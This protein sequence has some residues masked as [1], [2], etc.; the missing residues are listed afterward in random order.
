MTLRNPTTRAE[1]LE[2]IAATFDRQAR[3]NAKWAEE[4]QSD[5]VRGMAAAFELA[6]KWA[7]E[8]AEEYQ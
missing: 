7:R 4:I 8:N 6:A 3:L 1:V 5:H 2:E